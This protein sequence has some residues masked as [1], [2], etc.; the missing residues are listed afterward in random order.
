MI[1]KFNIKDNTLMR[2]EVTVQGPP[3]LLVHTI[4]NRLECYDKASSSFGHS[5]Y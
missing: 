1:E 3:I 5:S 2:Y 4:R